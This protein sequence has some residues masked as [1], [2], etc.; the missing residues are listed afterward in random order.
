MPLA[1]NALTDVPKAKGYCGI[2]AA[3]TSLDTLIESLIN[4]SS[5]AM[6][7]FCN[8]ILKAQDIIDEEYDGTG[9]AN[10]MLNQLN[11]NSITS[12]KVD[13]VLVD[14]SEYKLRKG[15]GIIV[16]LKS[17]WPKDVLNVKVTYNAGFVAVP[18]DLELA[19]KH[20]VKFYYKTDIADFS[21]T[22]GE[23]LVMSPEAWPRQVRALL[24]AYKK[25]LI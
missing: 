8:R 7:N 12:V 23:G 13:D 10:L 25:V 16:R 2:D 18:A 4:A 15:S 1:A 19:C 20:L 24:S 14:A 3:E 5:N 9:S 22:F 6:E 11:I 17:S 21:R